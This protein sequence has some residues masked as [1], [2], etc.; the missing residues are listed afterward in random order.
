M[1]FSAMHPF[2]GSTEGA[3]ILFNAFHKA[4][5]KPLLA[6]ASMA[7]DRTELADTGKFQIQ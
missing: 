2:I 5:G 1:G 4:K 7:T 6:L 3:D